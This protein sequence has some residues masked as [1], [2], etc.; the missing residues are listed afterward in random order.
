MVTVCAIDPGQQG[1]I[2]TL[3]V[4]SGCLTVA[5]MPKKLSFQALP[6]VVYIE[7]VGYHMLGNNAQSSATFARHVGYLLGWLEAK[8]TPVRMVAVKDWKIYCGIWGG[9]ENAKDRKIASKQ[10]AIK[11]WPQL[12]AVTNYTADAL[13]ILA[14]ALAK[15][16]AE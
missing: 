4:I 3:D 5:K 8:Y 13:C 6:T 2:A 9:H 16:E 10:Y 11:R 1:G 14:Y 7:D 12:S 15:M